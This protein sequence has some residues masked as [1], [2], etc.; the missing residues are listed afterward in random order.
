MSK[1]FAVEEATIHWREPRPELCEDFP[2]C[3]ALGIFD[4]V[5]LGH[6]AVIDSAVS[7]AKG[8]RGICA[9]WTFDP[10]PSRVLY[11]ENPTRLLMDSETKMEELFQIG[12]HAVVRKRF[13]RELS[14]LNAP[15]F[16]GLLHR[17]IPTIRSLHVGE[18]FRFGKNRSGG[19][20]EL[21]NEGKRYGI[22][23]FSIDRIRFNGEPVSSS[24]LRKT[25]REGGIRDV[26]T[27]L[28]FRY[29]SKGVVIPG[30]Q[31]G[32]SIGIP[33]LNMRWAPELCPKFGVYVVTV[34]DDQ[35]REVPGVA[36]YG[37]RPT[38]GDDDSPLLE[39]HLLEANPYEW[40]EGSVL[41]VSWIEFL[42]GERKFESIDVL[43]NQIQMDIRAA[44][45]F[46]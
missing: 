19:I 11:P 13:S 24:R 2:V 22:N 9:V 4:G 23:V 6:Q 41:K 1:L 28:G 38:V 17:S 45:S 16:V 25:I 44:K 15:E 30:K 26:N 37:L 3:L 31:L 42:R 46:F 27:M 12:V 40:S 36:N 43:K 39:V 8:L 18:N 35:S 21:V 10:H 5:H 7:A 20:E 29:F 14:E 32:S 34:V 33:T